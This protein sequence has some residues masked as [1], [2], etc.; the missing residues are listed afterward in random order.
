MRKNLF[1]DRVKFLGKE[2]WS[3]EKETGVSGG[4]ITR[5]F[6]HFRQLEM[7]IFFPSFLQHLKF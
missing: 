6:S 3:L 1:H 5:Q 2:Q 4:I 7:L